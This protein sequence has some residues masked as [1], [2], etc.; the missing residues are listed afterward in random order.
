[1]ADIVKI[2][3]KGLTSSQATLSA[4]AASQTA[5]IGGGADINAFLLVRNI[6]TNVTV[7]ATVKAG[8][9]LR[10]DLGDLKVD[11]AQS[12]SAA[13]PL[14]DSMRFG[15]YATT[16]TTKLGKVVVNITDTSD[17]ALGATPLSNTFLGLLQ[18]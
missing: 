15:L 17:S 5:P 10:K 12:T 9:G 18:G 2:Q 3:T 16:D 13:I 11:I 7:R 4:A 1:M 6:N 8:D 14:N